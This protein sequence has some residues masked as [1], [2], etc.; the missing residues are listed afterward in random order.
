LNH[1]V[2]LARALGLPS[3]AFYGI[4]QILGAGIYSVIGAAAGLAGEAMWLSFLLATAVALLTGLSYAELASSFPAAG[5]EYVYMR[6]AF[7]Q[8]S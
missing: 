1:D 5:A 7:P 2:R 3:L 8:W 6:H 4:G